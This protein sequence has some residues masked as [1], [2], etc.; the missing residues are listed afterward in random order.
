MTTC[1]GKGGRSAGGDRSPGWDLPDGRSVEIRCGAAKRSAGRLSSG[2]GCCLF[3]HQLRTVPIPCVSAHR[4]EG[5][6]GSGN[7]RRAAGPSGADLMY[8]AGLPT[9]FSILAHCW[10]LEAQFPI[11]LIE[12]CRE[13]FLLSRFLGGGRKQD[14]SQWHRIVFAGRPPESCRSSRG[15]RNPAPPSHSPRQRTFFACLP[16]FSLLSCPSSQR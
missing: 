13:L 9:N 8:D 1:H 16:S 10:G 5:E 12:L 14:T 2:R 3:T 11:R 4:S 6:G 7:R 15:R